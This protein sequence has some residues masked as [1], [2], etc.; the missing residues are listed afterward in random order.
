M[1]Y[2]EATPQYLA[3]IS[4][5]SFQSAIRFFGTLAVARVPREL[6]GLPPGEFSKNKQGDAIFAPATTFSPNFSEP[7][8]VE[9]LC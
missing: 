7:G 2:I 1:E 9:F 6:F 4:P 3:D 8:P 5:A